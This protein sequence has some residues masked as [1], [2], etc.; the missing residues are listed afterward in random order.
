M[1]LEEAFA[2]TLHRNSALESVGAIIYLA[3]QHIIER[4]IGA[5]CDAKYRG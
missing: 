2:V 5:L 4:I 3:N 1:I